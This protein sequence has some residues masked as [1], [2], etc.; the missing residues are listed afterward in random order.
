MTNL[1]VNLSFLLAQLINL[2]LMAVLL[3]GVFIIVRRLLRRAG[4]SPL[5]ILKGRLARGEISTQE[6]ERLRTLI[7]DEQS[8]KPKRRLDD[9]STV[10][11][12]YPMQ[13]E[14]ARNRQRSAH[15]DDG[16]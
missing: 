16:G 5:D 11:A 1:D 10:D 6:Y 13:S 8:A 3:A 9:D 7:V 12:A 14:S 2:F 4:D 15:D